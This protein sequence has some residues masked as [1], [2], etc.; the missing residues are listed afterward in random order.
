MPHFGLQCTVL[1][2]KK[3][4]QHFIYHTFDDELMQQFQE[5]YRID[6]TAI[7]EHV[8][9]Q[10]QPNRYLASFTKFLTA[11]RGHFMIENIIEDG[12]NDF[13]FTHLYKYTETWTMPIH[14]TGSIAWHFKD[15][16]EN[17]CGAMELQLGN[18]VKAP[19]EG[20]VAYHTG[21]A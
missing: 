12:L 14:F 10:P 9:Q 16:L 17:L 15:V 3:V 19:I 5:K 7:L 13:F 6:Y 20:L 2:G 21:K 4:L 1:L 8:Y 18:V 11:N